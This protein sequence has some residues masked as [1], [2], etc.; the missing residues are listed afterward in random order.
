MTCSTHAVI[1]FLSRCVMF[2]NSHHVSKV[3][4]IRRTFILG[5]FHRFQ[6]HRLVWKL[7]HCVWQEFGLSQRRCYFH[8]KVKLF[9]RKY[10]FREWNSSIWYAIALET[11]KWEIKKLKISFVSS[12]SFNNLTNFE[13]KT[14]LLLS[15][16]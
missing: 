8:C 13:M 2:I 9:Q 16:F 11:E 12:I 4:K 3:C 6:F 14:L 5:A 1:N 7:R 15:R 10:T